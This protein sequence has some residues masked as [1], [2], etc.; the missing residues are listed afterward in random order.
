MKY[1]AVCTAFLFGDEIISLM[2]LFLMLMLFFYD[3]ALAAVERG[4][5]K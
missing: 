1:L 5:R 3:I 4:E 2:A